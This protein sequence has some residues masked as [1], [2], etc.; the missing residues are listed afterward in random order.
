MSSLAHPAFKR[1]GD[2]AAGT[3]VVYRE[4]AEPRPN[5]PDAEPERPPMS[6]DLQE[7]RAIL[8]FAERAGSLSQARRGRARRP[9]G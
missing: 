6:L 9:P 1:L 5:L 8:A 4:Q 7:Q 3:L 2:I